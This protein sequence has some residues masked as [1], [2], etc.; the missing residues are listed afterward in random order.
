VLP[1]GAGNLAFDVITDKLTR[2][3]A[4]APLPDGRTLVTEKAG[5]MRLIGIDGVV[6]APLA[7]VPPVD[8][9]IQGGLLDVI[10]SASFSTDSTVF[11]SYTEPADGGTRV[12]IARATLGPGALSDLVIIY[13]QRTVRGGGLHYGTRLM[14]AADGT[15]FATLGERNYRPS[16]QALNTAFGKV[17]RLASDGSIPADNPFVNTVGALPEI[18]SYGHRSPQGAAIDP[19]SGKLWIS[20]HGPQGGDEINRI[21]PG[22][23]YGWPRISHG[24]EY[25]SGAPVGEGTNAPGV[26]PPAVLWIPVSIAPS[27]ILFFTGNTVPALTGKLL[28]ASLRGEALIALTLEG[29]TVVSEA[30]YATERNERIRDIR[31]GFDGY[32]YVITDTGRMLRVSVR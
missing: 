25:D 6:S 14:Q 29:E 19:R 2:P 8:D 17:I 31:Q 1:S 20:E 3:W 15:L 23:N 9:S 21:K 32:P 22:G 28:M 27:N 5:N 30:R 13:R 24:R 10:A 18:Y 4:F 16:A 7:G 26:V 12:A 11:F